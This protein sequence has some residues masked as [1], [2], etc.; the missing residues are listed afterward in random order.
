[1]KTIKDAKLIGGRDALLKRPEHMAL[2]GLITANWSQVEEDLALLYSYL[3]AQRGPPVRFGHPVDPLGV[4]MFFNF[5]SRPQR[6]KMLALCISD[7]ASE[8]MAKQ[9]EAVAKAVGQAAKLRNK[10]VHTRLG[11]DKN[12]E[13]AL[14]AIPL[15][16]DMFEISKSDLHDA[17]EAIEMARIAVLKFNGELRRRLNGD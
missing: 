11:V 17:L 15:V 4:E 14:V 1:M 7:R 3:L 6:M 2:I 13:D 8:E 10:L 12:R 16:G 9:F 5:P